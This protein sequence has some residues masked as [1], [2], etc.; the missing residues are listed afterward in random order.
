MSASLD[1]FAHDVFV[2]GR[3]ARVRLGNH[4]DRAVLRQLAL[5]APD[6]L[7]HQFGRRQIPMHGLGRRQSMLLESVTAGM[8]H[9][10][11]LGKSKCAMSD[12]DRQLYARLT[13]GTVCKGWGRYSTCAAAPNVVARAARCA[14]SSDDRGDQ[15]AGRHDLR[16]LTARHHHFILQQHLCQHIGALFAGLAAV[17]TKLAQAVVED[18]TPVTG[19]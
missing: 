11:L 4:H 6:G 14:S 2:V 8:S 15:L 12:S 1:G 3:A 9:D 17:A 19:L 5:A 13:I 10:D 7:L 16:A 18:R